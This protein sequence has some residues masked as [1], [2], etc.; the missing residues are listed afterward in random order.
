MSN[1][2]HKVINRVAK[3]FAIFLIIGIISGIINAVV[4]IVDGIVGK[5]EENK[6]VVTQK[7]DILPQSNGIEL[8]LKLQAVDVIIGEGEKFSY[9]T[10]NSYIN[11]TEGKDKIYI[12]EQKHNLAKTPNT[13]LNITIPTN[14]NFEILSIDG[15]AGNISIDKISANN[16]DIDLG[17]GNISINEIKAFGSADID[18]GAGNLVISSGEINN[19]DL[20]TGIGDAD[21]S[22]KLV[23]NSKIDSGV[24]KL[25][26]KLLGKQDDY[27]ISVSK[28][29]GVIKVDG[30]PCQDRAQVGVGASA[31][32][33]S[34]GVGD[35]NVSFV[36][37]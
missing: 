22:A 12:L 23:G 15:G 19:L 9:Q 11:V 3:V 2:L 1:S 17:A 30:Q 33:L 29:L 14:V 28:G 35:I 6:T 24:G 7:I 16:V 10:D 37:A 34:G 26:I 5:E 27:C 13:T 25:D 36:N 31:V 4:D 32:K 8:K 21:I 20:D 18:T